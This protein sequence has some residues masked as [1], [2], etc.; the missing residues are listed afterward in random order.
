MEKTLNIEG[1]MCE[2]CEAHVRK[3]LEGMEAVSEVKEV[4]HDKGIAVVALS[5]EVSD[6]EFSAAI[7][8]AGYDL[9]GV[10]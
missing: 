2:K 4:S 8:D 9:K 7:E 5:G 1:M 6:E 10:A 3:A